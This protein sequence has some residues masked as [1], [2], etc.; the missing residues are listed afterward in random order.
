MRA[1]PTNR[2]CSATTVRV[3]SL[4]I[5]PNGSMRTARGAPHHPH[6]QGKIERWHKTLKN[7]IL[8]ENYYLPGDLEA[9]SAASSST[10]ITAGIT[11]A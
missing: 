7:R 6:T 8:L 11:R 1:A 5:S 10:T 9:T 2:V 4:P 3:T